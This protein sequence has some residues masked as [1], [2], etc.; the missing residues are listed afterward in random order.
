MNNFCTEIEMN[1]YLKE[2][3]K[4]VNWGSYKYVFVEALKSIT[5]SHN[6]VYSF[7]KIKF[8]EFK[9]NPLS[10]IKSFSSDLQF[11]IYFRIWIYQLAFAPIE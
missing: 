6:D 3:I 10:F 5:Y 4:K 2:F 7:E 9:K 11:I 1:K 8:D